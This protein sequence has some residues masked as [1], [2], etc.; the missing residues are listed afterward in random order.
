[1]GRFLQ[2]K[3]IPVASQASCA[4]FPPPVVDAM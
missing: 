1:M 2:D 4:L 3:T